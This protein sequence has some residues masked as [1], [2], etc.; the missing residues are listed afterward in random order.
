MAQALKRSREIEPL[1][2]R[3]K[4]NALLIN[5]KNVGASVGV[6]IFERSKKVL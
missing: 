4:P 2:M 3:K 1:S 6:S 5:F